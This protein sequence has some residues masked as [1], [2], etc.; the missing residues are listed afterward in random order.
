MKHLFTARFTHWS[1][2][3]F[4]LVVLL[5]M[6]LSGT[7]QYIQLNCASVLHSRACQFSAEGSDT[8]LR[9]HQIDR[10]PHLH[11]PLLSATSNTC[12]PGFGFWMI[13]FWHRNLHNV[14]APIT[15]T[16]I[17]THQF[18]T[19]ICVEPRWV[20]KRPALERNTSWKFKAMESSV[21][22]PLLLIW[23]TKS[24]HHPVS[25]YICHDALAPCRNSLLTW[26]HS[27][28]SG[29][30]FCSWQHMYDSLV[31]HRIHQE[32]LFR[33]GFR[34]FNILQ[35]KLNESKSIT[36][37]LLS[38]LAKWNC[39]RMQTDKKLPG[40]WYFNSWRLAQNSEKKPQNLRKSPNRRLCGLAAF[41]WLY[42]PHLAD[43]MCNTWK[44][45]EFCRDEKQECCT[46]RSESC[47][48]RT[49]SHFQVRK[50]E[51]KHW[52]TLHP[53]VRQCDSAAVIFGEAIV[54][55][56]IFLQRIV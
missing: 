10:L 22:S 44:H 25:T 19:A 32:F 50:T 8:T 12:P 28:T 42:F 55:A 21:H 7:T 39:F 20:V 52:G 29:V 56:N 2:V 9:E 23:D 45:R 40:W 35:R 3:T 48:D 14:F 6:M 36:T 30:R 18:D 37:L 34:A 26:T 33:Q 1:L 11:F 5:P 47:S 31:A 38:L 46:I 49:W 24:I 16:A 4:C 27:L 43:Q 17:E 15:N 41:L 51:L 53:N 54:T 13:L